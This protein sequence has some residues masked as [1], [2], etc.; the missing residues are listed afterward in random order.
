MIGSP[1]GA[2]VGLSSQR[3]T[4]LHVEISIM[5]DQGIPHEWTQA[6]DVQVIRTNM[7]NI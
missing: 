2:F 1:I 6:T 7:T 3:K 5:Y 4:M